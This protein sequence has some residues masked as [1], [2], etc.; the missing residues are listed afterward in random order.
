MKVAL[1][2]SR[3]KDEGTRIKIDHKVL[4]MNK[5]IMEGITTSKRVENDTIED[6]RKA[7]SVRYEE[8][9]VVPEYSE[10]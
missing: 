1:T 7:I 9:E 5:K 6:H 8:V 4:E 10:D 2:F 3:R